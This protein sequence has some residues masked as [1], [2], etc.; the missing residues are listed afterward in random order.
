MILLVMYVGFWEGFFGMNMVM[1]IK[2][3]VFDV[4]VVKIYEMM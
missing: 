2:F 1:I 4:L 3:V